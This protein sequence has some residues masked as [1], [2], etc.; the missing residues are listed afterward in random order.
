MPSV[1][2]DDLARLG[3][4]HAVARS[5]MTITHAYTR[6]RVAL[7]AAALLSLSACGGSIATLPSMGAHPPGNEM[8]ERAAPVEERPGLDEESPPPFL[9][10]PGDVVRARAVVGDGLAVDRAS[11]DGE[12]KALFPLAGEVRLAG[13]SLAEATGR[14]NTALRAYDRFATVHLEVL[15]PL[16]HRATVL[17]V[18]T[19]PGVHPVGPSTRL[20]E[21]IALAGGPVANIAEGESLALADLSAATLLRAGRPLPVDVGRAIEGHPRHNVRVLA[22][23][24]L[25]VPASSGQ[26]ITV[27]GQVRSPR[28]IAF[29]P[30]IS[31]IDAIALAGG[32]TPEADN[33]DLRI[34]RGRLSR[35]SL[36]RA[37][38]GDVFNGRAPNPPLQPGD[39]V[40]VTEHWLATASQVLN[41]L[42]P[43]LAMAALTAGIVR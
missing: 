40:F 4:T 5:A 8:F 9:L 3:T 29:R 16:G 30:G 24:L 14:I 37:N 11:V 42:T 33:G 25:Y 41:R 6:A 34:V 21:L 31:L 27:L 10:A 39:I 18:V 28:T 43:L 35:P 2:V 7:S 12:G 19:S 15:E 23:D 20:A 26:R 36:Y 32:T 13:L 38:L 17:G 22:G 1:A